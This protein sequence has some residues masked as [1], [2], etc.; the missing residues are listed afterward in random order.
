MTLHYIT[1]HIKYEKQLMKPIIE[2]QN[3]SPSPNIL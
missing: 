3:G 1:K 2:A